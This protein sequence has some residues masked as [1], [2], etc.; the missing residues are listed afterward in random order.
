M[1][2]KQFNDNISLYIDD[3]LDSK[4][5]IEFENHLNECEKCK[6]EYEIINNIVNSL[7]SISEEKLPY[8]YCKKL[9]EKLKEVQKRKRKWNWKQYAAVA[10]AIVLIFAGGNAI[11]SSTGMKLTENL[12]TGSADWARG[13]A[14]AEMAEEPKSMPPEAVE[15]ADENNFGIAGEEVEKDDVALNDT[16]IKNKYDENVKELKI[17]KEG[18]VN[19]ETENYNEF[20]NSLIAIVKTF[21]GYIESQETY[22]NG[23]YAKIER[24]LKNGNI[25]LRVPQNKFYEI[26]DYVSEHGAIRSERTNETDVTKYYYEVDNK[27]KNLEVQ[28]ERLRDLLLKAENVTEILQIENELRRVRTDIDAYK[29]NLSDIDDR[30]SMSTI[31]IDIREVETLNKNINPVD[32]SVWQEAKEGFIRTINN[33]INFVENL[34]VFIVSILPI[35]VILGVIVV[36][37]LMIVKRRKNK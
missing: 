1:N 32:K 4:S 6:K 17:I 8:G 3:K 36:V 9:N 31:T 18:Y 37:V 15:Q 29:I 7:N 28:E 20:T 26:F 21:N 19:V 5:K 23:Y 35:I 12:D 10:A 24:D 13:D 34:I 30:S 33:I 14:P 16:A 27:V 25:I 2:C 11:L 22:S